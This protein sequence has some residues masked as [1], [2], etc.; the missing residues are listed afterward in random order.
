MSHKNNVLIINKEAYILTH[1][2]ISQV[3]KGAY[4]CKYC[5]CR[6]VT[7]DTAT[8]IVY[9]HK[10]NKIPCGPYTYLKKLTQGL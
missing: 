1:L 10:T 7:T 4:S 2:D 3:K 5:D 9:N 6:I 8:C